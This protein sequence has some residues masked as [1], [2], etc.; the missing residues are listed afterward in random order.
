[1]MEGKRI[2]LKVKE[3]HTFYGLSHILIR[4]RE[5]VCLLGRNGA[6]KTTTIRSI[7]GLTSPKLGSIEFQ[8]EN[9]TK[10]SAH[11]IA[12]KGI[13]CAFSEKRVFGDL[14]VKEN[15]E[16][17]ERNP[18]VDKGIEVW[19]FDRVYELF[20]V[21]KN[22]ERRL[23][24]T[25]S[26]GEQQMLCVARALM[27]N[28]RLLILDEPTTGLAPL[29]IKTVGEHISKL[30]DTGISILLAEQNVKFAMELGERCYI[31]DVGQ[32]RFQGTFDELSKNEYVV[33]T[34]LAV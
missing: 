31:I 26:G 10:M 23:S 18:L 24:K 6:G 12:R 9:I 13:M 20:P 7:A 29:I 19:D 30:R 16:I 14:T 2:L 4:E 3:I 33:R 5:I 8:E 27:G 15:L 21:L 25:L 17:S 1:M 28:P 34:Y 11:I 22:Y 32:V